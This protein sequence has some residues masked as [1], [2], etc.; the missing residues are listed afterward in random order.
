[1]KIIIYKHNQIKNYTINKKKK[2]FI[3]ILNNENKQENLTKEE[4][5]A[6]YPKK[7]E[8][9]VSRLDT[10]YRCSYQHFL[11]Y[12]LKLEERR[13]YTLDAPDMGQLFHEAL[14]VITDWVKTETRHIADVTKSDAKTYATKSSKHLGRDLQHH[15]I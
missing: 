6:F 11:Q 15:I 3:N 10:Y 9:S 13:T 14:K 1:Y 8:T 4:R 2:K 7:I 12:K 5:K